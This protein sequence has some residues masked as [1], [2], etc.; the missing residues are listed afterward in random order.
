MS[1]TSCQSDVMRN[2][3]DDTC[4]EINVQKSNENVQ[5]QCNKKKSF[6]CDVCNFLTL[7]ETVFNKHC[8][9][10]GH[11]VNVSL[12]EN[13]CYECEKCAYSTELKHNF[14]LHL[15]SQKHNKTD[16]I[17]TYICNNCNKDCKNYNSH[18]RHKQKCTV[19]LKATTEEKSATKNE[20]KEDDLTIREL[21]SQFFSFMREKDAEVKNLIM[22]LVKNMQPNN[23][24]NNTM[25]NS[26][27][28]MNNS[29]NTF[30][31]QF[32]LN[33]TCKDALNLSE[34]IESIKV[35]I[36]DLDNIGHAG[37][38]EG[39]TKI[40]IQQLRELGVEKRPIHC[41]D[42]KRQT[43]YVKEDNVWQKEGPD[44]KNIQFLIDQVQKINLRHLPV[45]RE[46][47]PNCLTS[48]SK[49]TSFYNHMSQELMGGDCRKIRMQEKDN[50]IMK[51]II[52]EVGIDK[53]LY[54]A[55]K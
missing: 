46:Q 29:N 33:E 36:Q 47:H 42:A 31:L 41:T 53:T 15:Q 32:F 21:Q 52:K 18:W 51:N 9:T 2:N 1:F 16:E 43:L 7:K 44:M 40:I 14:K 4:K 45:W 39:I 17:K 50:K 20:S 27:N 5:I 23:T 19:Q 37:Y 55:A 28:T 8:T 38:V 22:E 25:N 34:F 12:N 26:N 54:I 3:L 10:P 11:L 13:G 35:G 48:S 49:Y 30:N 24:T 6:L